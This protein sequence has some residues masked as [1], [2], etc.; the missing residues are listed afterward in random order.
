MFHKYAVDLMRNLDQIIKIL[1][2]FSIGCC[3]LVY[4]A[5]CGALRCELGVATKMNSGGCTVA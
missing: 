4:D 5:T 2:P 3:F 1:I